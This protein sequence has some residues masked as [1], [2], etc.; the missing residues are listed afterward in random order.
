MPPGKDQAYV[1]AASMKHVEDSDG[2]ILIVVQA[3]KGIPLNETEGLPFT[4]TISV[5]NGDVHAPAGAVV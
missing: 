5:T 2:V 4:V 1:V 3:V